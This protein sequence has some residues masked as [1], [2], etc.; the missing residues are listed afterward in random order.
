MA[1]TTAQISANVL[2]TP[3]GVPL[4]KQL[5]RA[6]RRSKMRAL[7]M[8]A[9]L[10]IF[11]LVSFLYPI[12]LMLTRSVHSP[13]FGAAFHRTA[14]ALQSWDG[15]DL[16]GEPAWEAF[17]NDMKEARAKRT[18]GKVATRF[19]YDV[20]GTRSLFTRTAR[21]I[22]KVEAPPYKDAVIAINKKWGDVKLWGNIK[23]ISAPYTMG[24]Y[25]NALDRRYDAAGEIVRQPE[26][27]QI[28]V[29][30]FWRTLWLSLL[31]GRRC[32][33]GLS[34]GLFAGQPATSDL[35]PVNDLGSAAILDVAS[36]A[37]DILDCI[38]AEPRGDQ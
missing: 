38:A 5:A 28:Y 27:R 13:E 3:D 29:P 34:G 4:K 15:K 33:V 2:T 36:R 32:C 26:T 12:V 10:G 25:L 7:L 1:D 16:P 19:N 31:D 6:T 24:F 30:L 20:P 18:I 35:Q 8:V 21:K 23:R 17:V 22:K 11:I 14:A 9:P 37:H